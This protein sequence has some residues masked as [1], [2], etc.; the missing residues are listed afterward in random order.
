MGLIFS[1]TPCI[2]I[3]VSI[4]KLYKKIFC[5]CYSTELKHMEYFY[6]PHLVTNATKPKV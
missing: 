5:I 6:R 2:E 4:I 3:V 1:D